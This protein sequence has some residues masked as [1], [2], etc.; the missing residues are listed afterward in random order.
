MPKPKKKNL[1]INTEPLLLSATEAFSSGDFSVDVEKGIF[2]NVAIITKGPALGHGF[3]IDD[4]TLRQVRASVNATEIGTKVRLTHPESGFFGGGDDA[5]EVMLGRA[6]NARISEGKVKGDIYL[7]K[8]SKK[9]PKGDLWGYLTEMADEDPEAAGLSISFIPGEHEKRTDSKDNLLPPACRVDKV[10]GVDFVGNPAA[11]PSGFLA[12]GSSISRKE[13]LMNKKLREFLVKLGL[14][15]DATDT[16]AL[17]YWHD[18]EGKHRLV[19]NAL[20]E[21]EPAKE[22]SKEPTKKPL[23]A[24]EETPE[25]KAAA[26]EKAVLLKDT[27]RRTAIKALAVENELSSEWAE[28]LCDR[29][30]S[31]AHAKE[32]TK[33][34]EEMKPVKVGDDL[35]KSTLAEAMEDA[36]SLRS[37]AKMIELDPDTGLAVRDENGKVKQRKPHERASKLRMLSLAGMGKHFLST[38]GVVDAEFISKTA[39]ADLLFNPLKLQ[40]MYGIVALAQGTSDFPFL[41]ANVMRK[42]LLAAYAE[43]PVDWPKFCTRGTQPDFKQFSLVAL[44][45][46]PDLERQYAGEG[47]DYGTVSERREVA[48]LAVYDKGLKFTRIMFVNDDLNAFNRI[49][50]MQ[51]LA[52]ARKEDDVGFAM[53]TGGIATETMSDGNFLFDAANHTNYVAAGGGAAPS[54]TTLNTAEAAMG[55]QRGMAGLSYLQIAPKM[56][57]IP[58]ALK[59]VVKQLLKS[60]VV[61]GANQGHSANVW[62]GKLDYFCNAR[63][64]TDSAVK[65]YLSGDPNMHDTIMLNF[66]ESEQTPVLRNKVDFDTEDLL[67]AVRHT[68]VAKAVDWRALYLNAGA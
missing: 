27:E 57:I 41:L 8:Y 32:L 31:L 58:F 28:G 64:D 61:P 43:A 65:W 36:I 62:A 66:L 25:A 37:G 21:G 53:L 46:A 38:L 51:G 3:E 9:S 4:K 29:G 50:R 56:I 60:T 15:E 45:E 18:L 13:I 59:G 48:T 24:P 39:L 52:A 14:S 68:L 67:F 54:I 49:P 20:A 30:V 19:A 7:G 35:D 6:R 34:A 42:T 55:I 63:L 17:E 26:A 11:N 47:V 23:E 10:V 1:S 2:R 16:Q 40:S 33:L 12:R 5:I 44:S 22:L